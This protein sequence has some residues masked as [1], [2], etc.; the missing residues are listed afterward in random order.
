MVVVEVVVVVLVVLVVEGLWRGEH[1]G[2]APA[3][4]GQKDTVSSTSAC[5][6]IAVHDLIMRVGCNGC[7]GGNTQGMHL[8][9][10][11]LENRIFLRTV[12]L[13]LADTTSTNAHTGAGCH[14]V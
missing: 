11:V 7:G 13:V 5:L 1:P 14:T 4:T 12:G 6:K 2:H 3:S 8:Q 9:A 10:Q